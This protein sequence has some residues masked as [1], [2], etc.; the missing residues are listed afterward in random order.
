M[1]TTVRTREMVEQQ[2]GLPLLSTLASVPTRRRQRRL[3]PSSEAGLVRQ[4]I[5]GE[6]QSE[7][8]R[9]L[10][11]RLKRLSNG[12]DIQTLLFTS[13]TLPDETATILVNL[14]L[15]AAQEGEKALLVDSNILSPTLHHLLQ[16]PLAP[17][18]LDMLAEPE[19]WQKSIQSTFMDNLHC[20]SGGTATV[21]RSVF[22][23]STFDLLLPHFRAAYDVIFFA[24]PPVQSCIDAVMLSVKM[25]ATCLVLTSGKS[26]L[27]TSLDAKIAL[28][29]VQ[30]NVIGVILVG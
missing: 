11:A 15:V 10:Y 27:D 13:P 23:S 8:L 16:C 2:L 3:P 12:Q 14:A 29:S 18:L 24:T 21:P 30:G 22:K 7:A 17:G 19:A 28:E 26:R 25:D 6:P 5:P 4:L 20:I 9:Y 1:D